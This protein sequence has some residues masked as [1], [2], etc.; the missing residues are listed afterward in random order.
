MTASDTSAGGPT[1]NIAEAEMEPE[2][3]V[4]VVEPTAAELAR[5]D[6]LI[7]AALLEELQDT[8]PVKFCVLPL[9]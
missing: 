7:L 2:L 6:A 9:V 3:A 4:I 1:V 5:P 8:E